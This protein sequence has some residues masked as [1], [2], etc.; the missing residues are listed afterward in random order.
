MRPM[1]A[2]IAAVNPLLIKTADLASSSG[3][4]AD[5]CRT[6]QSSATAAKCAGLWLRIVRAGAGRLAKETA[7]LVAMPID[8]VAPMLDQPGGALTSLAHRRTL[9]VDTRAV[10]YVHRAAPISFVQRSEVLRG[11]ISCQAGHAS[12]PCRRPTG[13][14]LS[15]SRPN[16]QLGSAGPTSDGLPS[17]TTG[18]PSND[19]AQRR[20]DPIDR[21]AEPLLCR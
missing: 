21:L 6:R 11:W 13:H 15:L 1:A 17:A 9:H 20:A 10:Y 5:A 12:L 4:H 2:A 7:T 18:G 8:R 3:D 16:D 19:I 14:A